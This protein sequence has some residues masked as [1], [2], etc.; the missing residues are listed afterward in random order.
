MAIWDTLNR[1]LKEND[2]VVSRRTDGLEIGVIINGM[3]KYKRGKYSND[4]WCHLIENPSKEELKIK[5]QIIA[6][7]IKIQKEK[8]STINKRA[9]KKRISTKDL[10][11]GDEYEDDKG[12][13]F[14]YLGKGYME[15]IRI[16]RSTNEVEVLDGK[17]SGY[18]YLKYSYGEFDFKNLFDYFGMCY[19]FQVRKTAKKLVSKTGRSLSLDKSIEIESEINNCE[20]YRFLYRIVLE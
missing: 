8:A 5:D 4:N 9:S 7:H 6:D 14:L 11:I 19:N 3:I 1:E 20:K 13:S 12:V 15:R 2:L 18:M 17:Y 16:L 10:V